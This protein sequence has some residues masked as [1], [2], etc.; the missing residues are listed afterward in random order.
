VRGLGQ[1]DAARVLA[2]LDA[3]VVTELSE[4]A[5]AERALHLLLESLDLLV[6]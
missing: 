2:H 6:A 5:H 3:Q 4:V 1:A